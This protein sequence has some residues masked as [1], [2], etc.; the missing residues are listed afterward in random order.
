MILKMSRGEEL[1]GCP[2]PGCGITKVYYQ[3]LPRNRRASAFYC[4]AVIA[5]CYS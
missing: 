5:T 2:D 3:T 1:A 4:T